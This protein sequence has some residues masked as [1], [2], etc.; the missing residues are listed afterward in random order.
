MRRIPWRWVFRGLWAAAAGYLIFAGI[1]AL[2]QAGKDYAEFDRALAEEPLSIDVDLTKPGRF[3][4]AVHAYPWAHGFWIDLKSSP[5]FADRKEV[6]RCLAGLSLRVRAEE[7]SGRW[8][9]EKEFTAE[10]LLGDRG[11]ESFDEFLLL[12][13]SAPADFR[14]TVEIAAPAPGAAGRT[15]RISGQHLICGM[16]ALGFAVERIIGVV[17]LALAGLIA[18]LLAWRILRERRKKDHPAVPEPAGGAG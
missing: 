16:E 17:L 2:I 7:K 18:G 8:R 1:G 10:S 6:L 5:S 4:A 3:E 12:R 11:S 15:C 9:E 13:F 14:F